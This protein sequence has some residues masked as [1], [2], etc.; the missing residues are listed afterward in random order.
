MK[1]EVY[2][3]IDEDHRYRTSGSTLFQ[4]S[5]CAERIARIQRRDESDLVLICTTCGSTN[6]VGY[7]RSFFGRIKYTCLNC[8][9]R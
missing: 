5:E 9:A 6:D 2:F 1:N 3:N 8:G 7:Y 4:C